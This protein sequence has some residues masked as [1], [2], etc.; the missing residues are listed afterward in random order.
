MFLVP[1][2]RDSATLLN[3]ITKINIEHYVINQNSCCIFLIPF[4]MV[5]FALYD[6][7]YDSVLVM[8]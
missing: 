7:K 6:F 1:S 4:S 8:E 3:A 5:P 2:F